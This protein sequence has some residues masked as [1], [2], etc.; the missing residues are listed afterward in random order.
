MR[1]IGHIMEEVVEPDNMNNAFD[2]VLRGRKRKESSEGKKLLAEREEVLANLTEQLVN[3]SFCITNYHEINIVEGGKPRLIQ[4]ISMKDRIAA[5]AVMSVVDKY[6]KRRFIRTTSAS[7]QGRGIHD[8]MKY[9]HRDIMDD[10]SG[11]AFCYKFDIQK[12]YESI[13]QDL[14]VKV[15]KKVFKD[16]RLL[17][18]L[19]NFIRMMPKGLSI[20]LRSSQGLGNLLLSTYLDHFFKDECGLKY[21]YRYCDDVVILSES[22]Q[23]LWLVRDIVH[24]RVASCGLKVKASERVFPTS[25]GIDFLGYVIFPTHIQLRK[26]VKQDFARRLAKVKSKRRRKELIG[27]AKG[28]MLHANCNHLFFSITGNKMKSFKDLGVAFRPKDGK[29]RFAGRVISISDLVNRP[30][31]VKDFE[32][33]VKTEYGDDRYVVAIEVNGENRKFFTNSEEM[34]DILCQIKEMPDGF[35]FETTI[36]SE[37][38]GK[39]RTKY[40]FT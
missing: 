31:I 28:M 7:I 4:V 5:H 26:R 21:Y 25:G 24:Q 19:E 12:F 9:I 27:A 20:G 30:I 14:M 3:G 36:K 8:L 15:I 37:P 17:S 22:K 34:K 39:G 40:I 23:R 38:F 29:K 6:L 2:Q 11:T 32:A 13:N 10:P 35:P 1:R 33:D 16:Q 18:V